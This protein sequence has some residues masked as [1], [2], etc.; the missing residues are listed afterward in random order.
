M[1]ARHGLEPRRISRAALDVLVGKHGDH[2]GGELDAFRCL[3]QGEADACAML[4]LNWDSWCKDGTVPLRKYQVLAT[5]E[6]FDHCVF[7][8][9]NDFSSALEKKWLDVL[10]SMSYDNP[11]HRKMMDMEGLKEWKQG[12]QR[13]DRCEA[14][15]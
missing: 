5:S 9:R 13:F 10:F 2:V 11:E 4:D 7:T 14:T 12:P 1:L 8:V 15:G 6:K 3:D